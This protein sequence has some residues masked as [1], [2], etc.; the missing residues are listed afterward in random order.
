MVIN[1]YILYQEKALK[2]TRPLATLDFRV[3]IIEQHSNEWLQEKNCVVGPS[4]T[5][6]ASNKERE[7]KYI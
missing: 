1:S 2:D 4:E 6:V 7:L 5:G 3:K